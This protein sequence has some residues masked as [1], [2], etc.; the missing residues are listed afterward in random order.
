MNFLFSMQ[1]APGLSTED[2]LL[3]V[4]TISFDIAA[5]ELFLPLIT[6][7]RVVLV[8]RTVAGDGRM[9]LNAIA[10]AS[11]TV[12]QATP[13]TWRLLLEAGW[14][15]C[16]KL[17]ILCG[18]EPMPGELAGELLQ[19]SS[20]VWNL[21]GPTETT[22]WSTVSRITPNETP[23]TIGRP[24]ANTSVYV[25]DGRLEPVPI[26]VCGELYIGGHGLARGYLNRPELT[27]ERFVPNPFSYAGSGD[28]LY[29]TGDVARY[30]S[31]GELECLGR[32]DNQ[33]K[34]RGFRVEL[35]EIESA[36]DSHP[37]I[38]QS[39]V[40]AF[41]DSSGG[42]QLVAY[43][44]VLAGEYFSSDDTR[45]YIKK[46]LPPHMVPSRIVVL[47][48]FPLTPN[49][50]VDRKALPP[51]EQ[52]PI[53]SQRSS[54]PP[55]N[56]TEAKLVKIWEAVLGVR[57]FG[58]NQ[59]FFELGGHSLMVAR[60]LHRLEQA[61]DAKLSM[62]SIF[63]APTIEQQASVLIGG[64]PSQRPSAIV[65]IQPGG[66]RP[67]LFCFGYRA[68]PILLPLARRIGPDQPLLGIDPTLLIPDQLTAPYTMEKIASRLAEQMMMIYPKG[69][70]YLGGFC[71]GGL[72]AYAA[73]SQLAA[74][75][76]HVEIVALFEPHTGH[77]EY[78]RYAGQKS[79][80]QT[81]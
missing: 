65:K 2:I 54:I 42:K 74:R 44:C 72:L 43:V 21:Y 12:M 17:K 61:F 34:I 77:G 47:E 56:S 37:S 48:S 80:D 1:A 50:K 69:P 75:K 70:F 10:E 8:S 28:R 15:G 40:A 57:G 53:E 45:D 52:I 23:I 9:L 39:V 63:E 16:E 32:I 51:P 6:G 29:K 60:L 62:A 59:S 5:L 25:L 22:V 64:E 7:A 33:V 36:L 73:A 41:D 71:G 26:G 11:P 35:G 58:V 79:E 4:T 67:P 81:Y 18:G 20:S 13:A 76:R 78:Q 24:I 14:R 3:A 46:K 68:G 38:S 49:R 19:R 30:R 27:A 31:N 55:R 66:S